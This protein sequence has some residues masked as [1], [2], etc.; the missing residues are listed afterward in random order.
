MT[1]GQGSLAKNGDQEVV[2]SYLKLHRYTPFV[3]RRTCQEVT[4]AQRHCIRFNELD[5]LEIFSDFS[6]GHLN[7]FNQ[8]FFL[9]TAELADFPQA[10]FTATAILLTYFTWEMVRLVQNIVSMNHFL[11]SNECGKY[12]AGAR[13]SATNQLSTVNA[14]EGTILCSVVHYENTFSNYLAGI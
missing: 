14:C 11:L 3:E 12:D 1:F 13:Y 10:T 6:H 5:Q 9:K 7:T 2:L 4:P 8:G